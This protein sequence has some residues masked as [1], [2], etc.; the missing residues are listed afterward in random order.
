VQ[1]TDVIDVA[2][3]IERRRIVRAQEPAPHRSAIRVSPRRCDKL[4]E[5]VGL[6]KRVRIYKCDPLTARSLLEAEVVAAGE[7]EIARRAHELHARKLPR[8]AFL[9]AVGARVVHHHDP[10]IAE[11]LRLERT[12]RAQDIPAA[13]EVAD[14]HGN[15]RHSGGRVFGCYRI[16]PSSLRKSIER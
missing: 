15:A 4:L 9:R 1:P 6:G 12:K 8:D 13:V 14:D 10:E 5:P 11:S 16:R 2:H 7:A 3:A